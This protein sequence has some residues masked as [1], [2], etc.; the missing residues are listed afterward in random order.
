ML[1]LVTYLYRRIHISLHHHPVV[2]SHL[3][4]DY[5][6]S[7]T[8]AHAPTKLMPIAPTNTNR[9]A[10][11]R[12]FPRSTRQL[13]SLRKSS[14]SSSTSD[15]YTSKPDEIAFMMP[16]IS[17]PTSEKGSYRVWVARPMA[18]PVGRL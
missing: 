12:R 1:F 5:N 11:T 17:R 3:I 2:T 15:A 9:Q 18:W 10:A 6:Y 4:S 8:H 14:E 13:S 7:L 16:T